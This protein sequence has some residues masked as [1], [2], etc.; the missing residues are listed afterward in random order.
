MRLLI[1]NAYLALQR[2]MASMKGISVEDQYLKFTETYPDIVQRVPQHM[3]A[4]YLGLTP[5]TVSRIRRRI[6][7]RKD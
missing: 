4:S 1:T 6:V 3:I 5:E 7:N 2:R